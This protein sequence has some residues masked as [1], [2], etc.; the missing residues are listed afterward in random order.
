MVVLGNEVT[1]ILRNSLFIFRFVLAILPWKRKTLY[2]KSWNLSDEKQNYLM[3]Q[4]KLSFTVIYCW[5][6]RH[7]CPYNIWTK[8]KIFGHCASV[9]GTAKRDS[10]KNSDLVYVWFPIRTKYSN[11]TNDHNDM[12][13]DRNEMMI[14]KLHTFTMAKESLNIVKKILISSI[15]C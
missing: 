13:I 1:K 9:W 11:H 15:D 6:R 12:L 10:S 2:R 5:F 3:S 14:E 7:K 4:A 8:F